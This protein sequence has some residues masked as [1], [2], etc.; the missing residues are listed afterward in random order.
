MRRA[1]AVEAKVI[2]AVNALA[3]L[4]HVP[5]QHSLRHLRLVEHQFSVVL[6]PFC[7]VVYIDFFKSKTS[8]NL[9]KFVE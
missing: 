8:Q 1:L 5:Y 3:G 4:H 9:I 6:F 7:N 2:I